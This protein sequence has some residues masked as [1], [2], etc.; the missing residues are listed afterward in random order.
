M[1]IGNILQQ[2]FARQQQAAGQQGLLQNQANLGGLS[3][4][5]GLF[6]LQ[7]GGLLGQFGG[8]GSQQA[9]V[10]APTVLNQLREKTI[11]AQGGAV[12]GIFG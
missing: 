10:G 9:L 12:Q 1:G 4:L 3:Q 7:Q 6:D 2:D 11:K 5:G 8:L